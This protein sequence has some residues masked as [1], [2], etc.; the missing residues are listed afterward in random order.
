MCAHS[1]AAG[2]NNLG[3]AYYDKKN[4]EEAYANFMMA[5]NQEGNNS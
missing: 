4:Y 3:L 2:Y 5:A 1:V